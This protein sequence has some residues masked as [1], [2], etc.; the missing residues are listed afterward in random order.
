M[1]IT[2]S[3]APGSG[4]NTIADL[5][6]EKLKLKRYSVGNF[7]REMA[8]KMKIT[9]A[10]LNALGEKNDF[11]DKDADDW[12]IKIGKK[13]DN[14]II[15]GRLSYHFI[16]NSIKIFLD[17]SPEVG[18]RRIKEHSRKEEMFENNEEALKK[19]YERYD[20]DKRRYTQ[21]YNLDPND[22]SQYDFVLDTS[23]L[24]IQEV[25]NRVQVFLDKNG[26]SN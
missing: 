21:Y 10:E 25:L 15:D 9:L 24:G 23:N 8:K 5:L 14:F 18:S 12:Q 17:V 6:A 3:G 1:I 22:K 7:R 19:W 2:I 20:S 13:E 16:P 4:K 11:T 26:K